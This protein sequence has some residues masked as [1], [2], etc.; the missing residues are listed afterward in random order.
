[1]D[2]SVQQVYMGLDDQGTEARFSSLFHSVHTSSGAHPA[3][4]P[5]GTEGLILQRYSNK[6]ITTERTYHSSV[7][8]VSSMCP[9]IQE[10]DLPL[11]H[12][13]RLFK[14][15]RFTCLSHVQIGQIHEGHVSA[16][17]PAIALV[18]LY[19]LVHEWDACPMG[20]I[21]NG[22]YSFTQKTSWTGFT[23][24]TPTH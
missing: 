4:Y 10:Q 6:R 15:N 8:E 5:V 3:F 14:W 21:C 24:T 12:M 2:Q 1:M 20:N 7:V 13:W 16:V 19:C 23:R 18:V 9:D 17:V 22:L 11:I